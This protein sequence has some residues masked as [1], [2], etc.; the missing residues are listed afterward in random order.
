MN[1]PEPPKNVI[2]IS[3][4]GEDFQK[5]DDEEAA[6]EEEDDKAG[7]EFMASMDKVPMDEQKEL[8]ESGPTRFNLIEIEHETFDNLR[9][10]GH[11]I[12]A[13]ITSDL[14][15]A[16][17]AAFEKVDGKLSTDCMQSGVFL[18]PRALNTNHKL[19]QTTAILSQGFEIDVCIQNQE[20]F[21]EASGKLKAKISSEI[22]SK[23]TDSYDVNHEDDFNAFI[24]P[25]VPVYLSRKPHSTAISNLGNV[26][27]ISAENA[28]VKDFLLTSNA[29]YMGMEKLYG[30]VCGTYA[31]SKLQCIVRTNRRMVSDKLANDFAQA[32]K[33]NLL[34]ASKDD[35]FMV[36]DTLSNQFETLQVS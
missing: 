24:Q 1:V 19:S 31:N 5:E 10:I 23:V 21:W 20:T 16:S 27:D 4:N 29:Y 17:F 26:N 7:E 28:R 9:K 15:V 30:L 11:E 36:I 2:Y 34:R 13:T 25:Y 12:G 32:F 6:E 22:A 35:R 8:E 14:L 33:E 18:D 3:G